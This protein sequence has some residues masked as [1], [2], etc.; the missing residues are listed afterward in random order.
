MGCSQ[1]GGVGEEAPL[2]VVAGGVF[3][4]PHLLCEGTG[5]DVGD[6]VEVCN[7]AGDAELPHTRVESASV[8]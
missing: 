1:V 2:G 3:L 4:P 6:G 5:V 8:A 7:G